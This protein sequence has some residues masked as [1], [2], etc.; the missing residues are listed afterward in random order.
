MKKFLFLMLLILI[1]G[2]GENREYGVFIGIGSERI[3]KLSAYKTVVIEPE[4]FTKEEVE[5]S[6][7]QEKEV[8]AY[9]NVGALEEYRY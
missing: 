3:S 7:S 6:K 4:N 1:T 9:L 2:C 8:Y 5:H